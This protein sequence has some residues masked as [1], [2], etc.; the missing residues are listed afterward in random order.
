MHGRAANRVNIRSL[1]PHHCHR[2]PI[3][4]V[5]SYVAVAKERI[6]PSPLIEG[7][8][9]F[10]VGLHGGSFSNRERIGEGRNQTPVEGSRTGSH[11]VTPTI[12]TRD[13]TIHR[14]RH[15]FPLEIPKT[16]TSSIRT[17]STIAGIPLPEFAQS[18][19]I[20]GGSGILLKGI[21]HDGLVPYWL[22][23][24]LTNVAVRTSLVPLVMDGAKTS[25]RL[26]KVTP[27]VQFLYSLFQQDLNRLKTRDDGGKSA[28]FE[29]VNL[30]VKARQTLKGIYKLH[31]VHPFSMFKVSGVCLGYEKI[32]CLRL[33]NCTAIIHSKTIII[34][35]SRIL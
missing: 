34:N 12:I 35:G 17:V 19:T 4:G 27:E 20:W 3:I 29:R 30:F 8:R 26:A 28:F 15:I 23:M 21:H 7:C 11:R 33:D 31:K 25:A 10:R 5:S 16:T 9:R 24:S 14:F 18:W 22:C 13:A 32:I 2:Q 1:L 6:H